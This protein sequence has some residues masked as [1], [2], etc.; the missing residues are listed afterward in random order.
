MKTQKLITIS[1]MAILV[2]SLLPGVLAQYGQVD[3]MQ[4]EVQAGNDSVEPLRIRER[5][6]TTAE[7][8]S[9]DSVEPLRIRE[10]VR[11]INA[12]D[13]ATPMP[14]ILPVRARL[15]KAREIAK[16][17]IEQARERYQIA[18]EKY[19]KAR[20]RY[21]IAKEK[22]TRAKT[23]LKEC[24]DGESEECVR[25]R[26]T[27]RSNSKDYLA[28]IA[29]KVI[30]TLEKIK[31]KIESNEQLSEEEASDLLEK[32]DTEIQEVEDAKD[33]IQD[34]TNQSSAEEVR[35]AVR[36]IKEAWKGTRVTLKKSVARLLNAKIGGIIV[37]SEQLEA[38]LQR[39]LTR[40]EAAGNDVT[41]LEDLIDK[42]HNK[43]EEAKDKWE[44][45][46]QKYAQA[47]KPGQ[48]DEAMKE[49]NQKIR[50]AHEKLKESHQTLKE[51]INKIREM[52]GA[53]EALE[54]EE[55]PEDNETQ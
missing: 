13:N 55:E 52:K 25:I 39:I 24:K 22:I 17:K 28:N 29:D 4:Q 36:T 14:V 51:I 2:L 27:I 18:K 20:E 23:A 15:E 9:N 49:V 44:Q 47:V 33:V 43:I 16:E 50:E 6:Q 45:A 30:A 7:I 40:L 5:V 10:R 38:K 31:S 46:R 21:Q 35:E 3:G 11:I 54:A 32:I 41:N 12:S 48:I 42:F 37:K 1:L 53:Q 26:Q 34:L 8:E 19:L